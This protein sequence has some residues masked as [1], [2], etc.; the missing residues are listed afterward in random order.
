MPPLMVH[1]VAV[2]EHRCM[3]AHLKHVR[4]VERKKYEENAQNHRKINV[5]KSAK[6]RVW[7]ERKFPSSEKSI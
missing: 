5:K 4:E 2:P 7:I 6:V 3:R 1:S